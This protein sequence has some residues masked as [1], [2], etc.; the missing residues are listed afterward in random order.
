MS[1]T[2]PNLPGN[3]DWQISDPGPAYDL[4]HKIGTQFR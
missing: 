4:D 1:S 2:M 3:S